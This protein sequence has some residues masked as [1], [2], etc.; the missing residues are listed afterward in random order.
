LGKKKKKR[1]WWLPDYYFNPPDKQP[2]E[3]NNYAYGDFSV[4]MCPS[5]RKAWELGLVGKKRIPVYYE[6]FPTLNLKEETCPGCK[7]KN[8]TD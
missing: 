4:T 5:C 2:G 3:V 8:E 7:E 6:D 1:I